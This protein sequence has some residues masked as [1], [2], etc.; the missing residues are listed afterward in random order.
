MNAPSRSGILE[1]SST[2]AI[3]F[4]VVVGL[5]LLALYFLDLS[6]DHEYP[7]GVRIGAFSINAIFLTGIA[8]LAKPQG[9]VWLII[10]C[11]A[12]AAVLTY[13]EIIAQFAHFVNFLLD[14]SDHIAVDHYRVHRLGIGLGLGT[15][16]FYLL[17]SADR[18]FFRVIAQ[19]MHFAIGVV[20]IGYHTFTGFIAYD[21]HRSIK[22]E[23]PASVSAF[24]QDKRLSPGQLCPV[25]KIRDVYCAEVL[26]DEELPDLS[27]YLLSRTVIDFA[28]N[29]SKSP[30]PREVVSL[31]HSAFDAT[32]GQVVSIAGGWI[33]MPWGGAL[34]LTKRPAILDL[35]FSAAISAVSL[36]NYLGWSLAALFL[37]P[38]HSRRKK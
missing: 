34:V 10:L 20:L 19:T 12:L 4:L 29:W 28:D 33:P 15:A 14:G 11:P 3:Q 1:E 9:S 17:M 38:I 35:S 18:S 8:A 25:S 23:L 13:F 6:M 27:P 30:F 7:F 37:L 31:D 21:E 36:I 16:I 5:S 32:Q 24:A 26:Y 2:P 22:R